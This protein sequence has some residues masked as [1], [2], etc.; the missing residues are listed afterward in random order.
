MVHENTASATRVKWDS[1]LKF[2]VKEESLKLGP[3]KC[4]QI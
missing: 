1:E 4:C 2:V 3:M